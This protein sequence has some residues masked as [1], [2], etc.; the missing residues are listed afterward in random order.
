[1]TEP[2]PRTA[3]LVLVNPRGETIGSL[4]P[5]AVPTPWWQD[6]GSVLEA[7]KTR[8]GIDLIILRLLETEL[9]GSAGGVVTYLAEAPSSFDPRAF[10][11][12]R[13]DGVLADDPL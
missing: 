11:I 10:P 3:R 1:M 9:I 7:A 5:F 6:T 13:W 8:Y 12:E 4:Q 2:L